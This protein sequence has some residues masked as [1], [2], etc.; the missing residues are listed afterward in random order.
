[1]RL[2]AALVLQPLQAHSSLVLHLVQLL[3]MH[4]T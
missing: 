4:Q 2:S 1:M 3:G